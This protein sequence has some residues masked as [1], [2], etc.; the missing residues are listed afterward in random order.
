[1]NE[2]QTTL[3]RLL[4]QSGKSTT[5]VAALGGIDRAYLLRLLNG[6]KQ[7]P[8]AETLMRL[9]LGLAMDAE[10]VKDYPTFVHGFV[11]LVTA[12]A[13]SAASLSMAEEN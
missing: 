7:N 6:T 1:M 2:F 8:S 11:E 4:A 3:K 13:M 5:Q 12:Q 9:W 10:V